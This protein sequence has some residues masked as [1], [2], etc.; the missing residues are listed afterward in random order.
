MGS[1]ITSDLLITQSQMEK[2]GDHTYS[3]RGTNQPSDAR[4]IR[5]HNEALTCT[6]SLSYRSLPHPATGYTPAEKLTHKK[7]L[8]LVQTDLEGKMEESK[9]HHT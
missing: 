3:V 2:L 5:T 6:V 8:I 9:H 1:N 7:H 4:Q